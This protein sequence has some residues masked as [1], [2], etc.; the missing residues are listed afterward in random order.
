MTDPDPVS[1]PSIAM[2]SLP[3][4]PPGAT[5]RAAR[6]A[7]QL[8]IALLVGLGL[9]APAWAQKPPNITAGEMALIPPYCPDTMGFN[10]GD[11]YTNTSPRAGYWISLMGK[12][13]WAVHHY[14]WGLIK[15]RR[16]DAI[17][18]SKEVRIGTLK[19]VIAEY[20][21]VLENSTPDFVLRPEVLLRRGD[22]QLKLGEI[23]NAMES[24]E[25]AIRHKP[26][27]WPAYVNWAEFLLSIKRNKDAQTFLERGLTQLPNEPKLRAAYKKA[28]GDPDTFVRKLPPRPAATA[29]SAPAAAESPASAAAGATASAAA[30]AAAAPASAASDGR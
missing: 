11:A 12:S 9:G 4:V 25:A 19:N 13:F 30:S 14:C 8:V 27:Y 29:A 5:A 17:G 24:Y 18:N 21:Y 16:A 10:Y 2:T 28:G 6:L 7:R 3:P 20:N 15:L 23:G 26:D 22:A 1:G